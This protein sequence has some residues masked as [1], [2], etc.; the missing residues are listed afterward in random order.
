MKHQLERL[1]LQVDRTTC[2]IKIAK[3]IFS[4]AKL[5]KEGSTVYRIQ[6][7]IDYAFF[8]KIVDRESLRHGSHPRVTISYKGFVIGNLHSDNLGLCF[9][10]PMKREET[11][12][13]TL[14]IVCD[15]SNTHDI[16]AISCEVIGYATL[17][18]CEMPLRSSKKRNMQNLETSRATSEGSSRKVSMC[19][20]INY[21]GLPLKQNAQGDVFDE[22][23]VLTGSMNTRHGVIKTP[24]Y[25]I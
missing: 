16:R 21:Y 5:L 13:F 24:I 25:G 10:I 4:P 2:T 20:Q 19:T 14:R 12:D 6:F 17:Y 18:T 15:S 23:G 8:A 9:S 3:E 11:Q 1:A 7:V 22:N